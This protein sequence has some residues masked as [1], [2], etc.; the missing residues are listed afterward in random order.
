M[1]QASLCTLQLSFSICVLEQTKKTLRLS[2]FNQPIYNIVNGTLVFTD[3]GKQEG[4]LTPQLAKRAL[5]F[6]W[7]IPDLERNG[8]RHSRFAVL[9]TVQQ[10]G[11]GG[12][13]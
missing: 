3:H 13:G 10:A 2:L 12:G 11:V 1:R 9:A 4:L 6:A 7:S 5:S 8:Q